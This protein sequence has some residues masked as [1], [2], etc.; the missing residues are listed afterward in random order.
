MKN[1]NPNQHGFLRKKSTDT[2]LLI[3]QAKIID[4]FNE[5][6]QLDVIYTDFEKFF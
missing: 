4:T 5:N 3:M 1:I 6:K 2:N